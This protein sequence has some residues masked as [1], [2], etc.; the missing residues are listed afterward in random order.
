MENAS[1][2]QLSPGMKF[3][4]CRIL[5]L[6]FVGAGAITLYLGIQSFN[7]ARASTNWPE[8]EGKIISSSVESHTSEKTG[9]SRDRSRSRGGTT[10]TTTYKAEVFYEYTVD[11]KTYNGNRVAYGN[12]S[13]SSPSRARRI[14]DRYPEGKE[15]SVYYQPDDPEECLLEPGMKLQTLFLPG[16]GLIFLCAGVAMFIFLPRAFKKGK[17]VV[18]PPDRRGL[19]D[20]AGF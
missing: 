5:P 11:G 8:A 20:S 13:T 17:V 3:F 12:V 10:T 9:S 18:G 2:K 14:V 19:D 4:F 16:F 1:S 15:I 7:K 6:F